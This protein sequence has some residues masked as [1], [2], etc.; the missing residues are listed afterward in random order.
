MQ[1]LLLVI[2]W[3]HGCIGIH[4]W[5]RLYPP[6]RRAF[7]LLLA[8]AV[9]IPLAALGGFVGRRQQRRLR[10]RGPARVRQP[11]GS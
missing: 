2:V 3:V 6:Y 11:E 4:F 9:V 5:L 7:P 1:S 10:D 8:L